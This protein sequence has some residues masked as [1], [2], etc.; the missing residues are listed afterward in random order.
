MD[1]QLERLAGSKR[2]SDCDGIR[3]AARRAGTFA[4]LEDAD[5]TIEYDDG[6]TIKAASCPPSARINLADRIIVSVSKE[7]HPIVAFVN[8]PFNFP[9]NSTT[10]RTVIKE[11]SIRG[12]AAPTALPPGSNTLTPTASASPTPV[13]TP[14]PAATDT[15]TPTPTAT[16]TGTLEP[17]VL[18]PTDAPTAIPTNTPTPTFT[19]TPTN[20]PVPI[21]G[22]EFRNFQQPSNSKITWDL[23]NNPNPGVLDVTVLSLSLAFPDN[24][25]RQLNQI[26][27]GGATIW[28]GPQTGSTATINP[29]DWLGTSGN[30]FIGV[31]DTQTFTLY[32]TK[33]MASSGYTILVITDNCVDPVS[34]SK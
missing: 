27:F 10:A 14:T 26:D 21:C 3:N 30:R 11:V 28:N 18:P 2:Y 24:G 25:G 34:G 4:N 16:T 1:L 6:T 5:I 33:N 29:N 9:V 20:T 31:G 17:T 8:I 12:T 15:E 7:F 13:D 19:P 22:L 23:Y 32:F